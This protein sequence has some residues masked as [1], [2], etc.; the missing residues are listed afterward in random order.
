MITHEPDCVN[1][2]RVEHFTATQPSNLGA[3]VV[4]CLSCGAQSTYCQPDMILV[5]GTEAYAV[6]WRLQPSRIAGQ[7]AP[8][9]YA[10]PDLNPLHPHADSV[11]PGSVRDR[12]PAHATHPW[13]DRP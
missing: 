13:K 6:A 4:R 7:L 11:A 10:D 1:P 3:S 9:D 5:P 12:I 8:A 2:D